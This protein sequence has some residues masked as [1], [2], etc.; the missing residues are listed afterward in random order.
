MTA[1]TMLRDAAREFDEAEIDR[2]SE[3]ACNAVDFVVGKLLQS[4]SMGSHL[5]I[6][7]GLDGD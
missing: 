2:D 1:D 3:P 4:I 6:P 7:F 5:L